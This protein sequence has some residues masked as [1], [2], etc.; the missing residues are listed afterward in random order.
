MSKIKTYEGFFDFFKKK[1]KS[2]ISISLIRDCLY[3]IIDEYR[4]KSQLNGFT[5]FTYKFNNDI[6]FNIKRGLSLSADHDDF[7][8]EYLPSQYPY[9]SYSSEFSVKNGIVTT[10]IQYKP[11]I[12]SDK[13]VNDILE[14]C[15]H[16]LTG[17][18]CKVDYFIGWSRDEGRSINNGWRYDN[19][20]YEIQNPQSWSH[21]MSMINKTVKKTTFVDRTRNITIRIIPK[22]N[23][24]ID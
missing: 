23:L 24:V 9:N 17:Y 7:M 10:T 3:D 1:D 5:N 8:D 14:E 18:G 15:S 4:I 6:I 16:K 20:K 19:S 13:E 11:N 12:I 21:F 22:S 2:N